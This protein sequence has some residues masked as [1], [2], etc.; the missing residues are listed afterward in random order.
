[1]A[2]GSVQEI[3]NALATAEAFAVSLL[4]G[5]LENAANGKLALNAEQTQALVAARAQEQA[6]YAFLVGAGAKPATTA[7]TLPDPGIATDPAKL[8]KTLIELEELFVAAYL[9]AAQEFAMLKEVKWVQHSMAIGAVEAEHR[10]AVRVL[11][12]EAGTLE[13]LPNDVAFEKAKFASVGAAAA[14]LKE[15]GFIGGAGAPMNYPGPGVID[16]AGVKYLQP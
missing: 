9:A 4:G 11:A 16:N 6:H 14:E 10:V 7:F 12:I 2:C 3:I 8:L 5:A 1:M 15:L 13:G